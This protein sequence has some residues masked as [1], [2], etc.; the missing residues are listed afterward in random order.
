MI[1]HFLA[2]GGVAQMGE[3]VLLVKL[4]GYW[5]DSGPRHG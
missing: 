2:V 1:M 3:R 5:F 4:T